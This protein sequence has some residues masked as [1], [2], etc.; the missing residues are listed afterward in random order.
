MTPTV[1]IIAA[2]GISFAMAP[3]YAGARTWF[4]WG[5]P[6]H[7]ASQTLNPTLS[8]LGIFYWLFTVGFALLGA[9]PLAAMVFSHRWRPASIGYAGVYLPTAVIATLALA[10][11]D[12]G[13]WVP[14]PT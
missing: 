8:G 9:V 6:A 1:G 10:V 5:H 4:G 3:A 14:A 7:P 11:F 2:S 13:G 12:A